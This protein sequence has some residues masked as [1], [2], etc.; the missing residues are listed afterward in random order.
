ML[1]IGNVT[2]KN[3][4]INGP[5]AGISNPVYRL[6]CCE[7]NV[8]LSVSEMVS[9]KAICYN[10]KKTLLMLRTYEN[11]HPVAIQLF[12][13]EVKTIV[14]AA[15]YL[16]KNTN[17]DIIDINMGCPV[18]KVIKAGAGS[19]LLT[20]P[21]LAF[22]IVS[23]I[24]KNVSKP[25]TVKLRLGFDD[26][27]INVVEMAKLMEKAGAS[28]ITIHARTRSQMY[29]GH[30]DWSYIKKVK[31]AVNIPVIGNGDVKS[32]EDY[33]KMIEETGCDGVMISRGGIGNPWL[34]DNLNSLY[35]GD[36]IIYEPSNKDR[37]NMCLEHAKRLVKYEENELIALK[38]MRTL[39]GYYL[40]GFEN[41]SKVRQKLSQITSIKELEEILENL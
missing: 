27:S 22:D 18:P 11:E 19:K 15:I 32:I 34:F 10:N 7:H 23:N 2:L 14:E 26:K 24:V 1:K 37:I 25:V 29:E 36:S 28:A 4:I 30:S 21:D 41:A 17:C 9:D 13:G 8:G 6:I 5:M 20:N 33:K 31:D 39:V 38:Q 12:G 40:K 3:N 16:D 35:V